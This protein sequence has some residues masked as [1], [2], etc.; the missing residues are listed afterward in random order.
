MERELLSWPERGRLWLRLGLRAAGAAAVA[1]FLRCALPPLLGLLLPFVLGLLVAWLLDPPI[2]WLQRR[3][4]VSRKLLSALI[5]LLIFC[6]PGGALAALVWAAVDELRALLENWGSLTAAAVSLLERADRWLRGR[7]RHLPQGGEGNESGLLHG[8]SGWLEGLDVSG[9][10]TSLAEHAPDLVSAV[11]G[12][13]V[14]AA[15]FLMAS[16]FL[17]EDYPR[18][19]LLV[20]GRIPT[21]TAAFF[22]RVKRIFTAALGGYLR[23]QLILT[24]GVFLILAVGFFVTGQPY[25]LVLAGALA[26]LDL[27]P[28]VGAGTV[29][30]PW[31][32]ADAFAG[33]YG[34]AVSF[35]VIWGLVAV[36][37]RVAEPRIL[38]G[39][40]GLSP[41]LSLLGIYAGMRLAGVVGMIAGPLVLLVC[42]NLGRQGVFRP[43]ARD[44]RRAAADIRAILRDERTEP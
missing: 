39:Q 11:S 15:V 23:S 44:L 31:A 42:V 28:I 22:R 40:T 2:R 13:A 32:V 33:R 27:I 19:R 17:T 10:L 26:V 7:N 30:V 20:A 8:L 43:A 9:W 24:L 18:L 37:R 6:I 38:G 12:F 36:F 41:I 4:S 5:L 3:L 16:C 14:A 21:G 35:A 29:M 25:A 1:V 34:H